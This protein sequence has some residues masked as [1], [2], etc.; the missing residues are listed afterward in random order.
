[1]MQF[2]NTI[3]WI[4]VVLLLAGGLFGFYKSH[5]KVSLITASVAAAVLVLTRVPGLFDHTLARSLDN[6][7]MAALII[8]FAIRLT[9]T[10]R[11]VPAGLLLC[12]TAV[13]LALINIRHS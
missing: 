3:F 13:V 7:I 12:V 9:K 1:M 8:V 5:S 4:Y 2:E 6:I 11:F 10:K